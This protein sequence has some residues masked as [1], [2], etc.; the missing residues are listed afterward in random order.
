MSRRQAPAGV[1]DLRGRILKL[2]AEPRY[3]PLDAVDL[4]K[5][6][7]L[8]SDARAQLRNVLRALEQQGAIARIRK[9][10]Y[11]LPQEANLCTGILRVSR[12]GNA[13]LDCGTEPH[14]FVSRENA[15]VAMNGDRVVARLVHEGHRQRGDT[16]GRPSAQ[17]IRIL[18]RANET[19]VGTLQASKRF[20]YVVPDDSR[21]V[22]N[23]YVLPDRD[24][25]PK[26]PEVGEK[27][28][29]RLEEWTS[30]ENNPEGRI[31]EVLGPAGAPGVDMLSIIRRNN[32]PTQFPEAV[33]AEAA[34]VPETVG[35]HD[36]HG[37]EDL[38]G[39]LIITIDPDDARD[40]DD[41]IHVRKVPGGWRLGVHIADV[42]ALRAHRRGAGPRG[43]RARQQRLPRG[44]RHSDAA[45]AAQQRRL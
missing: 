44:P 39:E 1:A 40:F 13:R 2:L 36:L 33:L 19:I 10:R 27:V 4:S 22:H 12:G 18:E 20:L 23:I 14:L 25:A 5:K 45:R 42:S 38:R 3:Q 31:I 6:L 24:G 15:G 41:A 9:D 17:V 16:R 26:A 21:I 35:P 8:Q 7:G 11:V 43:A 29:V 32:L 30:P 28:V 34:R 37:R